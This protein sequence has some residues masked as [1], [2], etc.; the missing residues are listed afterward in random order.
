MTVAEVACILLPHR[1]RSFSRQDQ[2]AMRAAQIFRE[3]FEWRW[4]PCVGLTAGS[5]AYVGLA[6]LIIPSQIDGSSHPPDGGPAVNA[7]TALTNTA[8]ASSLTQSSFAAAVPAAREPMH[9]PA[10]PTPTFNDAASPPRRGFSPPIDQ[11]PPPPPP[12]PPAPVQAAAA[13]TPTPGATPAPAPG[14]AAPPPTQQPVL[15][16][17]AAEPAP[18]P[19]APGESPAQQQ[20]LQ[21]QQTQ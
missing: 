7:A 1:G 11:P 14:Q 8:F 3:F 15:N 20:Q 10:P 17:S 21:Q 4:A 16:A 13:P 2:K 12:P 18:T 5:L 6:L 9:R 19:P